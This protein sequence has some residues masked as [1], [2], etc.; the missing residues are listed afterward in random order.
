MSS[1]LQDLYLQAHGATAILR[2]WSS[3]TRHGRPDWPLADYLASCEEMLARAF[4]QFEGFCRTGAFDD[5]NVR[6]CD[7]TQTLREL[8]AM[9]E[10]AEKF[11]IDDGTP[12]AI[13]PTFRASMNRA[14]EILAE[15]SF[16]T[17]MAAL[18]LNDEE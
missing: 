12:S 4:T 3:K 11:A 5:P 2:D 9:G 6:F 7:F 16:A 13:T 15:D 14:K 10:E 8:L 18:W 17:D 1:V